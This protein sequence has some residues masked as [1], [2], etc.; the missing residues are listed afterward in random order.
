[1]QTDI[2]LA[3]FGSPSMT[4][5]KLGVAT[6]EKETLSSESISMS[7]LIVPSIAAPIQ[8][9]IST[10]VYNMPH[11]RHL[12][13]AHPLTSERNFVTSLLIGTNYYWNF[14]Q[15]DIVHG[16]G[17]TAQHS[18]L[19]YL[20]SGPLPDILSNTTSSVLLQMASTMSS[21]DPSPPNLEDFW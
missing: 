11:I 16:E 4:H 2:A 17:F 15:D 5:Q 8:N 7:V 3:S 20:L 14:V 9:S 13:L 12:K 19:G 6:I 1:M 21:E 10:S 18:R